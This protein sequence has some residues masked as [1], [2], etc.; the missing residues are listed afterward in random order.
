[1]NDLI[2]KLKTLHTSLIDARSGYEEG[3]KDAQGKGLT[4]LFQELIALHAQDAAAVAEQLQR[5]GAPVDD[6]G[7][8][9]G[10]LD[11][12]VMKF[13]SLIT[14]LDDKILPNLVDGEEH[15]LVHY[16]DAIQASSPQNPEYPVLVAQRD[17]LK[18]RIEAMR[19]RA[20]P[21]SL[22]G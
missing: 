9:M 12:V 5:L 7:S 3:L 6:R 20:R 8:L 11:R 18:Q 4:P 16:D 15:V 10:T 19:E 14:Q 1:M 21:S 17:A 2:R 22:H 13:T